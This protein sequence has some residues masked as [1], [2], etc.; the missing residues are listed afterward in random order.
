MKHFKSILC[1]DFI[2]LYFL[3]YTTL[4]SYDGFDYPTGNLSGNNGGSGWQGPWQNL[5]TNGNNPGNQTGTSQNKVISSALTSSLGALGNSASLYQ[6]GASPFISYR[7]LSSPISLQSM[8]NSGKSL[9]VGFLMKGD[10]SNSGIY[11]GI[12]CVDGS[13]AK[14][15]L[16]KTSGTT[17]INVGLSES[18]AVA[19]S[20]GTEIATSSDTQFLVYNLSYKHNSSNQGYIQ[21]DT[22]SPFTSYHNVPIGSYIINDISR[23]N[24]TGI[25]LLS[26]SSSGISIDEIRFSDS[27]DDIFSISNPIPEPTSLITL[28]IA[29]LV[30][31]KR[32]K[33]R[34]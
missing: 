2:I 28:G 26:N 27:S 7:R 13:T 12:S 32:H 3:S 22:Y 19:L 6:S 9:W 14:M 31:K 23:Q 15:F 8:Y 29:G 5:Y 33:K 11:S 25:Q 1:I 18:Q 30:F 34:L 17:N 21:V 20:K 10:F 24:F 4:T 16:G